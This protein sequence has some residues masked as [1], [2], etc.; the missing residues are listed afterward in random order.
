MA[1]FGKLTITFLVYILIFLRPL[2]SEDNHKKNDTLPE[3]YL[4][5]IEYIKHWLNEQ[6]KKVA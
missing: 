4:D 3:D 5:H 1:N 2:W 6:N